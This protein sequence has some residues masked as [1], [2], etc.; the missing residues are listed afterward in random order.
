MFTVPRLTGLLRFYY[1]EVGAKQRD[2]TELEKLAQVAIDSSAID[3]LLDALR[4]K[5]NVDPR[6]S[7]VTFIFNTLTRFYEAQKGIQIGIDKFCRML[8]SQYG[9]DPREPEFLYSKSEK[10]LTD[11]RVLNTSSR[12]LDEPRWVHIMGDKSDTLIKSIFEDYYRR[13][14]LFLISRQN[15]DHLNYQL[16]IVK[17]GPADPSEIKKLLRYYYDA[18]VPGSKTDEELSSLIHDANQKKGYSLLYEALERKYKVN[19]LTFYEERNVAAQKIQ[20]FYRKRELTGVSTASNSESTLSEDVQN[21]SNSLFIALSDDDKTIPKRIADFSDADIITFFSQFY[22]KIDDKDKKSSEDL[23]QLVDTGRKIGFETL[24]LA[25]RKKYDIDP[26]IIFD[27]FQHSQKVQSHPIRLYE[28]AEENYNGCILVSYPIYVLPKSEGG[29][30]LKEKKFKCLEDLIKEEMFFSSERREYIL[31]SDFPTLPLLKANKRIESDVSELEFQ[32]LHGP[33]NKDEVSFRLHEAGFTEGIFLVSRS[34]T[35]KIFFLYSVV[36][37]DNNE[38]EE[39]KFTIT[40]GDKG[41]YELNG[42]SFGEASSLNIFLG[43]LFEKS[44]ALAPSG[45][46]LVLKKMILAPEPQQIDKL[47]DDQGLNKNES[48]T[49]DLSSP[50][51]DIE[52]EI[53]ARGLGSEKLESRKN[54]KSIEK[55]F[56]KI[57]H[58]DQSEISEDFILMHV[59]VQK[60]KNKWNSLSKNNIFLTV[61]LCYKNNAAFSEV[62]RSCVIPSNV[63]VTFPVFFIK[64]SYFN[65]NIHDMRD[66]LIRYSVHRSEDGKDNNIIGYADFKSDGKLATAGT[67]LQL[68][69]DDSNLFQKKGCGTIIIREM[70]HSTRPMINRDDTS[71]KFVHQSSKAE[72]DRDPNWEKMKILGLNSEVMEFS[73]E[74]Q[75]DAVW[76]RVGL[77]DTNGLFFICRYAYPDIQKKASFDS[78]LYFLQTMANSEPITFPINKLSDGTLECNTETYNNLVELADDYLGREISIHKEKIKIREMVLPVMGS[79]FRFSRD[80]FCNLNC[81]S[82]LHGLIGETEIEYRLNSKEGNFLL[83]RTFDDQTLSLSVVAEGKVVSLQVTTGNGNILEIDHENWGNHMTVEDL[84]RELSDERGTTGFPIKLRAQIMPLGGQQFSRPQIADK[85][86]ILRRKKRSVHRKQFSVLTTRE[87][88]DLLRSQIHYLDKLRSNFHPEN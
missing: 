7:Y 71:W 81:V 75:R 43:E 51:H 72:N 49:S 44:Q 13:P 6:D 78:P 82:W 58:R 73:I 17:Q 4:S 56:V 1:E 52:I 5:Y 85:L 22:R 9:K 42:V 35:S 37:T 84:I 68:Q 28:N 40:V 50:T 79:V 8:C 38:C 30:I 87:K 34:I 23:Q 33:L 3:S 45:F 29:F 24:F 61:S 63:N 77:K 36:T 18:I 12:F 86:E 14:G 11:P 16:T 64:Y 20:R 74:D 57:Y 21:N 60:L 80:N 65:D 19:P 31:P 15:T 47:I 2:E 83:S 88:E 41:F 39:K 70:S 76:E 26:Q 54:K 10:L 32:W 25:L 59:S 66:L 67:K 27:E 55:P 69:N 48:S 46:P 53:C 62:Y